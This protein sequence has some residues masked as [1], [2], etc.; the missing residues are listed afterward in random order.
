MN[1]PIAA[2]VVDEGGDVGGFLAHLPAILWQRRY[3]ILAPVVIG[4]IAALVAVFAWPPVYRS[5]AL[6]LVQSSQLP[7]EVVGGAGGESIDRRIARI[8]EQVT[9]RPD[10][11]ALIE[12]H[13]LY[14]QKRARK[15]LSTVITDMRN[16]ITLT[17]TTVNVPLGQAEQ[18]TIAFELAYDYDEP[19]A[20]QAVA[21]DLM[22]RIVDLDASG[23]AEQASNT[24]QFLSDQAKGLET[25]IAEIQGQRTAISSR[26]GGVLAG[27]GM[28][29]GGNSGSYDVQ[30]AALQ[31]DNSMMVGQ[32]DLAKTSDTRDPAVVS[33]EAALAGARAV[34]SES[35]PDVI[36]AKQRLAESRE[37]A[38][39]NSRK[40]PV[41]LIDQQIA[42]NNSQIAA[43]RAAK[44]QDQAQVSSSLSAQARA[45]LVQQQLGQLEQQLTGLNEQYQEVSRRLMAAKAGVRA[46]DEQMG[47]RLAV[48][49][50]PVVPDKPSSPNRELL[51]G[52]GLGG[53]LFLGLLLALGVEMLFR[54]I[55]D[56]MA[57]ERLVGRPPLGVIPVIGPR[58]KPDPGL[59]QPSA[60]SQTEGTMVMEDFDRER[61]P[62]IADRE[63]G[64]CRV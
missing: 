55:R 29:M 34:F 10:L 19:V 51:A 7:N 45:P 46:E 39:G 59:A 54:P 23:S 26:N 25:R 12:E 22:E 33:A 17:P 27:G 5:S 4:A 49:E 41:D 14:R 30:I 2:E 56:P 13:G 52:M 31:R 62:M 64:D 44:A 20:A 16:S 21:Q 3:L 8:K 35:H 38:K 58:K 11:V 42:F 50:P 1:Q 36:L 15:P 32:R 53:G 18:R 61:E 37:F 40:M 57:L 47:Q 24:V 63:F 60:L 43:L 9:S 48:V 28:M 6:M